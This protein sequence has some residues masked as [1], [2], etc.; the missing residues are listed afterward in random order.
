M[1][2][3]KT[4]GIFPKVLSCWWWK[5]SNSYTKISGFNVDANTNQRIW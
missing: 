3:V 2:N 4:V 5:I 1:M